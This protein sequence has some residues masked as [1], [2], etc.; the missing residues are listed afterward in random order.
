MTKKQ[1]FVDEDSGDCI[2]LSNLS[3]CS[4]M[5]ENTAKNDT[6][7]NSSGKLANEIGWLI[8]S[9]SDRN[10]N[11]ESD[12]INF[13]NIVPGNISRTVD[14][15][16]LFI[17]E[18]DSCLETLDECSLQGTDFQYQKMSSEIA[19]DNI[20]D[21]DITPRASS[22]VMS[23]KIQSPDGTDTVPFFLKSSPKA[24]RKSKKK[25]NIE[26]NYVIQEEELSLK[27][28]MEDIDRILN[29]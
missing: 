19:D 17:A 7:K 22:P 27:S 20:D 13:N 15:T 1:E 21:G 5:L 24:S 12:T 11:S 16:S 4:T 9:E 25:K 14:E 2:D 6:I 26:E 3:I 10:N 28:L 18:S 8:S 29:A 23:E